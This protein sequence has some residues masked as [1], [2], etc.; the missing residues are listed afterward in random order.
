M[1][2]AELKLPEGTTPGP[3]VLPLS[4]IRILDLTRL[5]PGPFATLVLADLGADVVRV[6]DPRGGDWL[7]GLPPVAGEQA[8]AFHALNR[9]KRSLALDLRAPA[10]AATFRRLARRADAVIESFRPGVLDRLGLGFEALR[11]ENPRLVLASI[12]GYGQDG[13]YAGRA[14]HDLD[15]C[16]FAGVLAA[17]GTREAPLPLG[18]Q[19]ADLAGGS[20]PAV[21]GV[22]AALL[23]ARATGEGAHVDVSMTEGVL[24]LLAMPLAIAGARG[25]SIARGGELLNGGAACYG[26]YRTKDGRFVALGALEPK[27][28]RT[29]CAA[30]GRPDLADRQLESDGAGPRAELEALF[31]TRT[32]D[33]W[34]AFAAEHDVCL[35]P[36][37]EGD[38]PRADPQLRARGA[39]VAVETPYEGRAMPGVATPIRLRGE[40]APR[41][42]APRLGEHG[43]EVLRDA[44][45]DDGEIA[46]LRAAGVLG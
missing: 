44:G 31:A 23:R 7:R 22:L 11:A 28:F 43:A 39:F 40:V 45:L 24:A 2:F 15:Y 32:R 3:A 6:E 30:V 33:A 9:N 14:G 20:W 36:V 16:A 17:N 10:G 46:A 38:E 8:E 19:V 27:F 29:F 41:R 42:P 37:L 34:A 18:V 21:A 13:P 12:T 35:A 26:V 1:T 5:L 25:A 4:G